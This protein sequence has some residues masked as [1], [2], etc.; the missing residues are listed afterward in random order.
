ME[1]VLVLA[2]WWIGNLYSLKF[3]VLNNATQYLEN[4]TPQVPMGGWSL[5]SHL[6]V[7]MLPVDQYVTSITILAQL[8]TH[9]PKVS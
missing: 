4:M 9:V 5:F 7:D 1:V 3:W 8:N 6:Y 2:Y